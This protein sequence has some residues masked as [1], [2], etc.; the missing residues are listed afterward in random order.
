MVNCPKCGSYNPTGSKFCT[1]CGNS[2]NATSAKITKTD[3]PSNGIDR[4][5]LECIIY[6][7]G[8]LVCVYLFLRG[9]WNSFISPIIFGFGQYDPN[10]N[11]LLELAF[12]FIGF[13]GGYILLLFLD[14][15][16]AQLNKEKK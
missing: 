6:V 15:T 12:I 14:D 5:K 7:I 11:P 10:Y 3:T 8:V 13:F 16:V 9:L 4:T 2:L 1:A